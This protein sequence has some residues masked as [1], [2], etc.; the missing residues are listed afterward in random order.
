MALGPT[1]ILITYIV[2]F[3]LW[4]FAV[5]Y[6]GSF[7][8]APRPEPTNPAPLPVSE[9]DCSNKIFKAS[10]VLSHR[11]CLFR[12]GKIDLWLVID[13]HVYDVRPPRTLMY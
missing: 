8:P 13:G 4:T 11:T 5:L 3:L 9:G 6:A 2:L 1:H 12:E 7:Y 10:D